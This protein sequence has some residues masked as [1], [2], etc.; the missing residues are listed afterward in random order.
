MKVTED[1]LDLILL[2]LNR[3]E[4]RLTAIEKRLSEQEESDKEI[5]DIVNKLDVSVQA[6]FKKMDI[7]I[8]KLKR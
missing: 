6:K 4:S 7:D 5:R 8:E 1:I 3:I 2:R